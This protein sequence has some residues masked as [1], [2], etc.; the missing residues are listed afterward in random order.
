MEDLYKTAN[1]IEKK[2]PSKRVTNIQEE[3][4]NAQFQKFQREKLEEQF[5]Q[6]KMERMASV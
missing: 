1:F 6:F 5:R 3:D 4:I 2:K